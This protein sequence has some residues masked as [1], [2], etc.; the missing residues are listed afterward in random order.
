M[1]LT[2]SRLKQMIREEIKNVLAEAPFYYD[3]FGRKGA[4]SRRATTGAA[5]AALGGIGGDGRPKRKPPG[6][7]PRHTLEPVQYPE[8]A[9]TAQDKRKPPAKERRRRSALDPATDKELK[10]MSRRG[11]KP[12]ADLILGP[13]GEVRRSRAADTAP[14][15]LRDIGD[16]ALRGSKRALSRLQQLAKSKPSARA[17]LD[18]VYEE[19]PSL[20]PKRKPSGLSRM[21]LEYIEDN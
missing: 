6:P 16:A 12:G 19:D 8:P 17:I 3:G 13:D 2:E 20:K 9:T 14:D 10:M 21:D 7:V 11:K 4:V 5:V 1:K 18:A 15:A